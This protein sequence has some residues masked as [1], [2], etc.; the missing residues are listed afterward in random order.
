[1]LASPAR[2]ATCTQRGVCTLLNKCSYVLI[3]NKESGIF[4]FVSW[5][6][7][8]FLGVKTVGFWNKEQN[9]T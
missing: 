7:G 6:N 5:L 4:K 9:P 2:V 8:S 3:T 1:L